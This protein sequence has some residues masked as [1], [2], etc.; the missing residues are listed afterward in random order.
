MQISA[1]LLVL[2]AAVLHASWNLIVKAS[3]DRLVAAAIQL[4]FGAALSIPVLTFQTLPVKALPYIV[5]SSFVHLGYVLALVG[6]Y[7]RADLSLVYPI[8][9]GSAPVLVT[10]GAA[11]FL[12]D[13]PGGWGLGAIGLVVIG[14]FVVGIRGSGPGVNWALSTS[15]FIAGY[16]VI[17]GAAVRALDDSF[18]YTLAA[19]VG[20]AATLVPVVL[21]RR[22]LSSITA[23]ARFEWPR[24]LFA[25][26]ASVAAYVMV[27]AAARVAP[28]GL[29]SA[30]RETSVLFGAIGGWLLLKEGMGARRLNGAALIAAG[31]VV[32]ILAG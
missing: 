4:T 13:V 32:L 24:H 27:L 1:L 16:S 23:V 9:R 18:P 17:D 6:A 28:L 31:V 7:D 19:F 20:F 22:G 21:W 8:A 26:V 10:L 15:V 29:V 12:D 3:S 11:L 25:A 5:A 30:F 2:A 14:V